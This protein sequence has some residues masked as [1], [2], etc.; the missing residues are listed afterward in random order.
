[1]HGL[2]PDFPVSIFNGARLSAVRPLT[3]IFYFDFVRNVAPADSG[4][5]AT[6]SLGVENTWRLHSDHGGVVASATGSE[7][8][9]V[10]VI[11][12]FV[13]QQ[14]TAANVVSERSFTFTFE[15]GVQVEILDDSDEYE[16]FCIP[17]LAIYI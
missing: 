15:S 4:W 10:N 9:A 8:P 2:Q 3:G 7:G 12:E 5:P 16:T 11:G 17:E 14:V 13:G 1:M 6:F